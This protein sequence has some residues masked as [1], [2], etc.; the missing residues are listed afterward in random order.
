[1]ITHIN[2]L[3]GSSGGNPGN[4]GDAIFQEAGYG[5]FDC[6]ELNGDSISGESE[7]RS[8]AVELDGKNFKGA[9]TDSSYPKG[10]YVYDKDDVYW[11]EDPVGSAEEYSSPICKVEGKNNI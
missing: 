6:S 7:C 5:K 3:V 1:M 2:L 8:A 9:E 4:T 11:N 10:C